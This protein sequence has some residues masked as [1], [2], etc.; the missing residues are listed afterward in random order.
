MPIFCPNCGLEVADGKKFCSSCGAKIE[1]SPQPQPQAQPPQSQQPQQPEPE[2]PEDDDPFDKTVASLSPVQPVQ[3]QPPPQ[4]PQPQIFQPQSQPPQYPPPQS[5]YANPAYNNTSS[6]SNANPNAGVAP[7]KGSL[8]APIGMVGYVLLMALMCI[9]LIGWLVAVLM[10]VSKGNINRRNLARA[11]L[12]LTLTGI[13]I[14][15]A[16]FIVCAVLSVNVT[17]GLNDVT[18]IFGF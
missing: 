13:L 6:A 11:M 1:S 16:L 15:A 9:P 17:I 5:Q 18:I 12:V 7:P 3:Q 14:L 8:Y 2:P 10:A 4:S